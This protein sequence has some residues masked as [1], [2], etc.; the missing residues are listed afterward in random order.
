M[1]EVFESTFVYIQKGFEQFI[2]SKLEIE[3]K[4]LDFQILVS[5]SFDKQNYSNFY[6]YD[7]FVQI[8]FDYELTTYLCIWLRRIIENNENSLSLP[9]NISEKQ[10]P[11]IKYFTNIAELKNV[12]D[13]IAYCA[14]AIK[15]DSKII[16]NEHFTFKEFFKVIN[17]FPVWNFY[18]NKMVSI[19]R[20]LAQ[21]NAITEMYGHSVIY[22][23]TLPVELDKEDKHTGISGTNYT[24][25]N[26]TIR[27][28]VS[29][30][31][32]H[33]LIP[34]N[35]IPQ[36]RTIY[37]DWDMPLQDDF[38]IHITKQKF[39]QA[40]GFESIPNEKDYI[41]FP[42][43][44]KL[45]RVTT[46]QP[47]NGFMNV[48]A[49]YECFLMKYEADDC[50]TISSDLASLVDLENSDI[51]N[52]FEIIESDGLLD[53]DK[54]DSNTVEERNSRT[55]QM[56]NKLE[57]TT[58]GV[59]LK[60]T[61]AI[62]ESYN[63]R[64]EIVSVNP[65]DSLFPVTMYNCNSISKK[66][67]AL[68]YNTNEYSKINH[69]S[70]QVKSEINLS[71]NFVLQ[72]RF[73]AEILDFNLNDF[74][75]KLSGKKLTVCEVTDTGLKENTFDFEFEPLEFYQICFN[76]DTVK[77]VVSIK[78]NVSSSAFGPKKRMELK[79][80]DIYRYETNINR[81]ETIHIY[82]GFY[83]INDIYL[84]LDKH[85]FINDKCLPLLEKLES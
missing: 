66:E 43:L 78:I 50:V 77:K 75:L 21:C 33:I 15:Y 62:R 39:Q 69:Y 51:L 1:F 48:V 63:N 83:L 13:V 35:D 23:K 68:T 11:S 10:A 20:W 57:D 80:Q 37:T 24:L 27:N 71:F 73:N 65:S 9:T 81:V 47:K 36:D 4:K 18:D 52:D 14:V 46:M 38:V 53:K 82:G 17:E 60:E 84:K 19:Q 6:D 74:V 56:S 49:W 79:F 64:L 44:N 2:P 54:I 5:Y 42:L 85:I 30:K 72:K 28:V 12:R 34:N 8:S 32:I 55:N 31:K 29:I 58:H 40:F 61:E 41:Y 59:S 67:I 45:Y 76:F 7:D 3:N 26:N 22:F 16:E 25:A 70:N